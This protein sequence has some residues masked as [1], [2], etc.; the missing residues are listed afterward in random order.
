MKSFAA[1]A[2]ALASFACAAP[3]TSRLDTRDTTEIDGV[4]YNVFNHAA[5]GGQLQFVNNSGVCETTPGV[6][7]YSG[8][9]SI[10]NN[11][12]MWFWFFESRN[13]PTTAPLV[14]WFN[15]GPGCS[16][17][18]GYVELICSSHKL[19]VEANAVQQSLPRERPL[20]LPQRLDSYRA[21]A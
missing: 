12:N 4:Q 3:T 17:M 8:Y 11:Q 13:N 15:G 14:S 21:R 1:A 2:L 7:Q 9:F 10:G 19:P 20:S 6:N 18:I 5:T 16:S